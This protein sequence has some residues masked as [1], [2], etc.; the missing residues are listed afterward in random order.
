MFWISVIKDTLLVIKEKMFWIVESIFIFI[1]CTI[2]V[3][4]NLQLNNMNI[5]TNSVFQ[6][7][8][9][10]TIA[11]ATMTFTPI[12][13]YHREQRNGGFSY[14]MATGMNIKKYVLSKG[15]VL[16]IRIY[17]PSFIFLVVLSA[18]NIFYRII[19]IVL[20]FFCALNMSFWYTYEIIYSINPMKTTGRASMLA[21][22]LF[23]L[24]SIST[25]IEMNYI[26]YNLLLL[27]FYIINIFSYSI[28]VKKVNSLQVESIICRR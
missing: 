15:M 23:V 1:V 7:S 25:R 21:M 3:M 9:P 18:P 11:Y 20:I 26:N 14:L 28:F 24:L 19:H 13:D 17:I 10:L 4:M 6:L 5:S 8:F 27:T 12:G 16:G 2:A 22:G